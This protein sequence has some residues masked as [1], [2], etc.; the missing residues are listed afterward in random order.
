MHGVFS[1][2]RPQRQSWPGGIC[3]ATRCNPPRIGLAL[4]LYD[5]VVT[6]L[7]GS[8][9]R[10]NYQTVEPRVQSRHEPGETSGEK[11]SGFYHGSKA[12]LA[13]TAHIEDYQRITGGQKSIAQLLAMLEAAR[14]E[15]E[16]VA[17]NPTTQSSS[18]RESSAE[19]V[20]LILSAG[21]FWPELTS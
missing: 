11:G 5:N 7:Q 18:V 3:D 4:A 2:A 16:P 20:G 8:Y 15:F 14:I 10:D 6:L 19:I 17:T 1:S 12:A 9:R 13:R 21:F